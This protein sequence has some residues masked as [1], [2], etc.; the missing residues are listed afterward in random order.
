MQ[1]VKLELQK[2]LAR[3]LRAGHPWVFRRALE[4]P[5]SG[6][7]AGAIVDV[8]EKG[9][10]VARGY[11]DPHSHISVRVL[12]LDPAEAVGPHFFRRRIARAI[13]LRRAFSPF[14]DPARTDCVR[15]VHGENDW[16]PGVVV[17]LYGK[18][19]VPKLYSAGLG[20]HRAEI[21]D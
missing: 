6:L 8:V 11:Y 16:L 12:T 4:K 2:D 15:L 19:A 3:H 17:D 1:A 10:F 13:A 9:R 18:F 14:S 5:P 21:V 20:P 7:A